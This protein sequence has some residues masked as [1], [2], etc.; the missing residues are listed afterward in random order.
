VPDDGQGPPQ[1]NITASPKRVRSACIPS[2]VR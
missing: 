2:A 1:K